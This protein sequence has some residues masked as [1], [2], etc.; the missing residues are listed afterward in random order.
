LKNETLSG[1]KVLE[2]GDFVS[3]PYCG[4]LLADLGAEVIKV[5][6]TGR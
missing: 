5:E 6:K 1:L 2:Y 3:A 4:K